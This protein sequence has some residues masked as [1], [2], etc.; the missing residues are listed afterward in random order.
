MKKLLYFFILFL[1]QQ[2]QVF[3]DEYLYPV[4]FVGTRCCVMYQKDS[5]RLELWFWDP[6]TFLAT[7]G[8]LSAYTPAGVCI[9]PHKQ[10]FSFID[11]DR[12]R[13]K[14]FDKRSPKTLDFYGPY[15]LSTLQWLDDENFY[16]SACERN[17]F[18]LFHGTIDGDLYRLTNNKEYNYLYPQKIDSELFFIEEKKE[19][20]YAL[21]QTLYPKELLT[22][23]I[24]EHEK[25]SLESSL[26]AILE[27]SYTSMEKIYIER[28]AINRLFVVSNDRV[29]AFL[30]MENRLNGY[31]I[32]HPALVNRTDETI[33]FSYKKFSY[34]NDEW[35]I[36]TLFSFTLPLYLFIT[37]S[38]SRERLY[39]SILPLLPV[40]SC[41]DI[42]YNIYYSDFNFKTGAINIFCYSQLTGES[43]QKTFGIC[44]EDLYFAPIVHDGV[45]FY[46]GRL[47]NSDKNQELLPQ[48]FIELDEQQHFNFPYFDF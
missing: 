6:S 8:L 42:V 12:I 15:D 35:V 11:N 40:H 7:K 2:T 5:S 33:E 37:K 46:G 38:T 13:I 25:E 47:H 27:N 29:I 3:T 41:T 39:E 21:C 1:L 23:T 16:F 14:F 22:K 43:I 28:A 10:A 48:I 4:D 30:K 45:V 24:H 44:S 18:N 19:N 34:V 20:S 36:K 9:L 26:K 32:E 31:F 17:H